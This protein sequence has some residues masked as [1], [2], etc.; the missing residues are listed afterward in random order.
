VTLS[1]GLTVNLVGKSA[2][3]ASTTITVSDNPE[4]LAS[5]FS[6]FAG[7]YNAA[8]D[9]ISQY[10]GQNGGTLE[11]SSLVQSLTGV[12]NQL[13]TYGS[14]SPTSALANFGITVDETGTLSIDTAAF[15][16]AANANFSTLLSTLGGTT[17]GGFL[18]AATN[19]LS[20][21]EDPAAG[22]IKIEEASVASQIT[23][24]QATISSEQARVNQL[25]TNL[26]AQISQA[27]S[28]IAELESQV[29]Y[30]TGLF[31]QYTGA[32]STQSN[33]LATL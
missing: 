5:A 9:A 10:H 7:S 31:A 6:S 16:T 28:T 17:T 21:V 20:G 33:G 4:A 24:Q 19:L 26:T 23:D 29:S 11:G 3:N 27:D 25:Q 13:G 1:P 18:Q 30:V 2:A 32:N 14:G 15:T 22:A 8:L 12:L